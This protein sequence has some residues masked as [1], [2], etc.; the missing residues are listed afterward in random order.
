MTSNMLWAAALL[1][2]VQGWLYMYVGHRLTH[3]KVSSEASLAHQSFL[4]WWFGLGGLSLLQAAILV[5]YNLAALPMWLYQSVSQ[6]AIVFLT[7]ALAGLMYYLI[8]VYTGNRRWAVGVVLYYVLFFIGIQALVFYPG[9]PTGLVDNGWS[10]SAEPVLDLNRM[11]SL[12]VLAVLI[13]PQLAVAVAYFALLRKATDATQ[14]YRIAMVSG[15]F[16]IW[17][18]A[19]FVAG[20]LEAAGDLWQL[21]SRVLSVIAAVAILVAYEPPRSWRRRWGLRGIDDEAETPPAPA[22]PESARQP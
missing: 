21:T 12:A 10:V 13:G 4:S 8:Y 19:S 5:L 1:A 20:A 3:R 14:R 7:V 22:A 16:T 15:S 2:A 11:Q 6:M 17:F 18:G 9:A